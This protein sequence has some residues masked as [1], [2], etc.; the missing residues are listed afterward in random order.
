M[1]FDF[2][3]MR[4][5]EKMETEGVWC[6]GP[7]DSKFLIARFMNKRQRE[8]VAKNGS[9]LRISI[10]AGIDATEESQELTKTAVAKFVLLDWK[11]V[12]LDGNELAYTEE[13]VLRLF[14]EVP[15]FY[16]LILT[17]AQDRTRFK[18]ADIQGK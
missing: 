11:G 9:K 5:D 3:K 7:G 8:W 13:N 14:S 12:A 6:D 15:E 2:K 16:D 17:W 4:T 18:E 1:G 10:Q